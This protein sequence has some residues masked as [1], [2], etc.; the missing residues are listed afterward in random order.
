MHF[1][2]IQRTNSCVG[3]NQGMCY[4]KPMVVFGER[5]QGHVSRLKEAWQKKVTDQDLV[6]LCGD[7]SWAMRL[8]A[9]KVD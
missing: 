4:N 3:K 5:W 6:I 8:E 1:L 9:A 7:L 2:N